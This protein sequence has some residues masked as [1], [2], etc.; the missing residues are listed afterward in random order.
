MTSDP[1]I[2][3]PPTEPMKTTASPPN[4]VPLSSPM[5]EPQRWSEQEIALARRIHRTLLPRDD[6]EDERV[7]WAVRCLEHDRLGGDYCTVR[8]VGEDRLFLCIC[9]V[10]GHGLPAA[11]MAGRINS[12]VRHE[13]EDASHPCEVVH[14]LNAFLTRNFSGLGVF[15]TFFCAL[16]DFRDSR[17]YYAGAGH[18]P[19]L[20]SGKDGGGSVALVSD[21]PMLGVLDEEGFPCRV[22]S[23]PLENGDR[24]L[25]YTDGL[26]EARDAKG[27]F[28]DQTGLESAFGG[29]KK[30]ESPGLFANALVGQL[31]EFSGAES[32]D[33][34][35]L[36]L[37]LAVK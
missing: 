20:L 26:V 16:L 9:D 36:L 10:T 6:H 22:C 14:H 4:A 7:Q 28:F 1:A 37:A 18:P 27:N 3:Y 17:I 19:A 23:Q 35:V 8:Y 33:D 15:A 13:T 24:L 30:E 34:D 32:F 21:S 2:S 29:W 25:L 11:L 31:T 5:P 12:F